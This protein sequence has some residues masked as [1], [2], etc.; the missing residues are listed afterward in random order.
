M[1]K[2]AYLESEMW[3]PRCS[4]VIADLEAFQWGYCSNQDVWP[5]DVYRLGDAIR[6]RVCASGV[7]F[8]WVYFRRSFPTGAGN[9]GDPAIRNL[10][11][12]VAKAYFQDRPVELGTCEACEQT[13]AGAMIE[14]RDGVLVRARVLMPEDAASS[15]AGYTIVGS[16]DARI[17]IPE[18]DDHPMILIDDC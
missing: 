10:N 3:C 14:V 7:V 16:D 18:W 4:R 2:F 15:N 8:S 17:P 12:R 5:G 1:P 11:V 9:I 13:L 6:W